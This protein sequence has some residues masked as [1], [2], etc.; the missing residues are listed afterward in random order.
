MN[1]R[2]GHEGTRS[3][4]SHK[5]FCS[6]YA[7][8]C[9]RAYFPLSRDPNPHAVAHVQDL[10]LED[11]RERQLDHHSRLDKISLVVV[12]MEND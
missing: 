12:R 4:Y 8:T 9:D 5:L 10:S 7:V 3:F 2:Q 1:G 6:T 11:L